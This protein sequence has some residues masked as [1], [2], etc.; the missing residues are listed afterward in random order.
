MSETSTDNIDSINIGSTVDDEPM[1]VSL[2]TT[3]TPDELWARWQFLRE[4]TDKADAQ[5]SA[6]GQRWKET[7]DP[8]ARD[9]MWVEYEAQ[10]REFRVLAAWKELFYTAFIFS[11]DGADCA[12]LDDSPL[13]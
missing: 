1:E 3:A 4:L 9:R 12:A 2:T 5:I 13:G 6:I 8:V 11:T 7:T 10:T